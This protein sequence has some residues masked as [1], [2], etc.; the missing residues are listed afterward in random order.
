MTCFCV[1]AQGVYRDGT[2]WKT[3][4]VVQE[5][6]VRKCEGHEAYTTATA[7]MTQIRTENQAYSRAMVLIKRSNP[8]AKVRIWYVDPTTRVVNMEVEDAD[9]GLQ[10]DLNAIANLDV[11]Y[12]TGA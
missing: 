1:I 3:A 11:T 7:L 6:I 8:A 4:T 12:T 10:A 9:A 5:S 2:D